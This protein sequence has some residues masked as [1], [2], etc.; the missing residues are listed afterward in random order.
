MEQ[1]ADKTTDLHVAL[2]SPMVVELDRIARER[3]VRRVQVL[4][5]AVAEYVLRTEAERRAADMR[6]YVDEMAD[7]SGELVA[8]TEAHT[9]ERLLRE[10]EW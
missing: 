9:V 1:G 3:G 10:A 8:E 2:P 4:R 6:A 5:E 7:A